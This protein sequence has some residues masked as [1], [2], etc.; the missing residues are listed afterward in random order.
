MA[1][2]AA[3]LEL[4]MAIG[5]APVGRGVGERRTTR[6]MTLFEPSTRL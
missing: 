6:P 5:V 1:T 3:V 2:V 4:A